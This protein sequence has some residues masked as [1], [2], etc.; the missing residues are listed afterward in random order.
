MMFKLTDSAA[1]SWVTI[2]P[3]RGG[4]VTSF[5]AGDYEALYMNEKTFHDKEANVRGGIPIL[6]PISGQ[7]ENGEYTLKGKTYKMKN[8]GFARN[9]PWQAVKSRTEEGASVTLVL[10][11]SE[12]TRMSYPFDFRLEFTYILKGTTLTIEQEYKNF[13]AEALPLYPGFHPYFAADDKNLDYETDARTYFDYNDGTIHSVRE[14]LH[15]AGKKESLALLDAITGEISF[16]VKDR[17]IRMT[18]GKEFKYVYL[19]TEE[20][21]DFVCVEPWMARTGEFHRGEELVEIA[22]GDS[23]MTRLSISID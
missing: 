16:P 2:A 4:L 11:S 10:L 7:L 18:Y 15:L 20:G 23:L 22:P 19:W 14:G 8:H 6:F 1:G 12:N 21:G 3:G 13:S 17:R 5:G 9:L